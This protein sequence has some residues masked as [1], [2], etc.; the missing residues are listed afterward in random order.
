MG[1]P[2][3]KVG[4]VFETGNYGDCEVIKY[5]SYRKVTVRFFDTGTEVVVQGGDLKKGEVRDPYRPYL[6]GVGY[7]GGATTRISGVLLK[8]YTVWADMLRRCY[9]NE[10][11]SYARY[12]A[13]GVTVRE[14]WHNYSNF[15]EWYDSNAVEGYHLD[16]DLLSGSSKI[17]SEDTCCAL[18]AHINMAL[19]CGSSNRTSNLHDGVVKQYNGFR[20]T[21]CVHGTHRYLGYFNTPE[22][23]HQA[24]RV[25]KV[26]YIQE[27]AQ[28]SY[29]KG[30]ITE[31]VYEALMRWEPPIS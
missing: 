7:T 17:Y 11:E 22:E 10:Y 31:R 23:A 12:G 24:W 28:E 21:I 15:K 25:A 4:D 5:E 30:E 26:K 2:S 20:S 14:D 19:Q 9:V 16:K 1:K 8:S 6:Y 18:P 3:I 29:S 13:K 27:L